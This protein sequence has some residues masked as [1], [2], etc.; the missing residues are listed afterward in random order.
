M[1]GA[2]AQVVYIKERQDREKQKAI[3]YDSNLQIEATRGKW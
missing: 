3:M 1:M 2:T